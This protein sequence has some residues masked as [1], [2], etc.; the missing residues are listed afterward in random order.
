MA[1]KTLSPIFC[2]N[3]GAPHACYTL[4][5]TMQG[6]TLPVEYWAPQFDRSLDGDF[7]RPG[8]PLPI[9]RALGA[10]GLY[11]KPPVAAWTKRRLEQMYL[12]SLREGDIAYLWPAVS[13][14]LY[15]EI[16]NRGIPIV[17]ER[18]NCH[19]KTAMRVLREAYEKLGWPSESRITEE[20]LAIETEK[21]ALADYV[22]APSNNVAASLLD[23]GV[24]ETRLL[25]SSYG[26]DPARFRFEDRV[27]NDPACPVFLFVGRVCVRKGVPWLL[28]MWERAGIQGRLLLFLLGSMEEQVAQRGA[29]LLERDDVVIPED[30]S[31][32]NDAYRQADVFIFPTLEEGSPLVSYEALAWSLPCLVSPMGAGEIIRDGIEGFVMDPYDIDL[33]VD[34]IRLLAGDRALR[35]RLAQ[36]A[37]QRALEFTWAK[38]GARRRDQLRRIASP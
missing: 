4:M 33:W 24:S 16:K 6:E 18:I 9:Y 23:A 2:R 29:R 27:A 38:V 20:S 1:L 17:A 28:E 34:R 11:H 12:D 30:T 15:R 35:A 32:I 13:V 26:W 19:R 31:D 3:K 5:K 37:G 10:L 14:E 22:F 8:L 25:R 7:L 21:M 36:A